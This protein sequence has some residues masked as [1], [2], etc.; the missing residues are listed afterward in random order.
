MGVGKSTVG[1]RVAE[2]LGR[3]FVDLDSLVV[4]Q[5]GL[6][7]PQIFREQG[8]AGFR[9]LEHAAL[10]GLLRGPPL[11][12]ALGGGTLH[13]PE[14]RPLVAQLD[15]VVLTAPWR[16]LAPRIRASDRPL[17]AQA[18]ALLAARQAAEAAAGPRVPVAG[19]DPDAVAA[20]VL[21]LVEAG[22][23]TR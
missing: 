14:N 21:A 16:V 20:R 18:E 8:E 23:W 7:I 2:A 13:Q 5:A 3:P 6:P 15:V 10:A 17:L 12:I 11:V 9:A 1:P 4:A 19:L 22:A